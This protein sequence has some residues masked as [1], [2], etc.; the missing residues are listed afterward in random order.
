MY[1]ILTNVEC[2][3]SP[4][5]EMN[6]PMRS[7]ESDHGAASSSTNTTDLFQHCECILQEGFDR[8]TKLNN[9]LRKPSKDINDVYHPD[10]KVFPIYFPLTFSPYV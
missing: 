10:M 1:N 5:I 2:E 9:L 8:L 3:P 7:T 4:I 6:D